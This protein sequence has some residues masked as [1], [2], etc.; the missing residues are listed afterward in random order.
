[1]LLTSVIVILREVLE[2]ALLI[3]VL[4][5]MGNILGLRRHWLLF[6]LLLG[7]GGAF[8]LSAGVNG[9]SEWFDGVGQEVVSGAMQAV[10]FA[11]ILS[12]VIL[13][14]SSISTILALTL[15]LIMTLIVSLAL[16]RE[17]FEILI[18]AST[19]TAQ[20]E[21]IRHVL[22]GML[23]G[24]SI[25]VSAGVLLYYL[26]SH[27]LLSRSPTPG[28]VLL[29]LLGSGILSQAVLLFIQADWVPAQL[30]LWD[31][32]EWLSE[33]SVT[34][35]LLYVLIGYEAT[36][37]PIQVAVYI[38]GFL[39]LLGFSLRNHYSTSTGA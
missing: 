4:L 29:S 20:A 28:F 34:G 22:P 8:G 6:A 9:I 3:S 37:T 1:M 7:F 18:F 2:A 35:Q 30:P 24:A 25:G 17:G 14:R 16:A 21:Q 19:F 12:F 23:V 31:S 13:T 38:C 5:A 32:S 33:R 39:A 36:P 15:H 26:L 10:I 27:P 11:L